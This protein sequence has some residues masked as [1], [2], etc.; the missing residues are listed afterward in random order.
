MRFVFAPMLVGLSVL[1]SGCSLLEDATRNTF[2]SLRKPIEEHRENVRNRRWAESAWSQVCSANPGRFSGDYARGFQ[3]GYAEYLFR[4]G[5]G[6]PPLVPPLRYRH[7]KYQ[8]QAG[9]A[10]IQDWFDGFRHGALVARESGAR[11]WITGPSALPSEPIRAA[12]PEELPPPT[13]MRRDAKIVPAE[14][15]PTLPGP[16]PGE[17]VEIP[18]PTESVDSET[19]KPRVPTRPFVELVVPTPIPPPPAEAPE[20]EPPQPAI[21]PGDAD[22]LT[23]RVPRR[24]VVEVETPATSI[25]PSAPAIPISREVVPVA[26]VPAKANP[27]GRKLVEFQMELVPNGPNPPRQGVLLPPAAPPTTTQRPIGDIRIA[28]SERG[29]MVPAT[30]ST[31]STGVPKESD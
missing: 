3:E 30:S 25:E 13:P 24:P 14:K 29:P 12:V 15:L 21:E 31:G 1:S 22:L 8:T 5:D 9:F 11:Q 20:A 2:Y 28:P 23:P 4:G 17:R 7:I 10:A 26:P 19:P 6:E 18:L 16:V 27:P